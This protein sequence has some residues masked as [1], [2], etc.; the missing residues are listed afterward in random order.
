[1][2][3]S[4]ISK[5]LQTEGAKKGYTPDQINK[6]LKMIKKGKINLENLAP[7]ITDK[8][9]FKSSNPTRS[10]LKSRLNKKI[11]DCRKGRSGIKQASSVIPPSDNKEN[12]VPSVSKKNKGKN[13]KLNKL[14]KKY[15]TITPEIYFDALSHIKEYSSLSRPLTN[16]EIL[17]K[18]RYKNIISVYDK[19]NKVSD[20]L[21]DDISSSEDDE[22]I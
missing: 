14:A 18:N 3:L 19:Q 7:M 8:L 15:G 4:E 20:A 17:E 13:K 22:L 16:V 9:D 5:M 1:M 21:D 12:I 10:E 2:D 6:T 11:A